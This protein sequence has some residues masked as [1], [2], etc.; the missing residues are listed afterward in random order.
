[1]LIEMQHVFKTY[2][3][4]VVALSDIT[5]SID[6]GEFVYLIGPSGAGKSTWLK[7]LYREELPTK[8]KMM[9]NG[10][11][12]SRF[13]RRHLHRLRRSIGV[14]F[15]DYRLID[16]LTVEE[17]IAFALEVIEAPA[18]EI[19]R[20]VQE[21]LYL[22]GLK[23]HAKRFPRELSGGEQ[24]RIAIARA[25]ANKPQLIIADEPTGNLDYENSLQILKLLEE[26]NLQGTTVIMATHDRD[27]V[28][29][30]RR[31]VLELSGGRLVRDEA[32]GV[33]DRP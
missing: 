3:N 25:L 9:V 18:R 22:V 5:L 17:N 24:Q 4:G 14:V 1:V 19:R 20:R 21:L 31:R 29:R 27:I 8:G 7:L 32:K 13:K 12:F 2:K 33:Y 30:F 28:N 10:F 15:Q 16:R 23:V 26:I 11:D 6:K